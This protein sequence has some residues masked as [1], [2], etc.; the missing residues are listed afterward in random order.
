MP[1]PK[2]RYSISTT[3]S[4]EGLGN[5]LIDK[6]QNINQLW[7]IDTFTLGSPQLHKDFR[8]RNFIS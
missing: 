2:N 3:I 7:R 1:N 4:K 5:K 6:L 8:S